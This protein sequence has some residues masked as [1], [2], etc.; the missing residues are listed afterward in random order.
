MKDGRRCTQ[1]LF[2]LGDA[3]GLELPLL[4]PHGAVQAVVPRPVSVGLFPRSPSSRAHVEDLHR[5]GP[6]P[7]SSALEREHAAFR[8]VGA[9]LRPAPPPERGSPSLRGGAER[10]LVEADG[11]DR[12]DVCPQRRLALVLPGQQPVGKRGAGGGRGPEVSVVG[13]GVSVQ[14]DVQQR[15]EEPGLPPPRQAEL[16]QLPQEAALFLHLLGAVELEAASE[17]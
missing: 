16:L 8:P 12:V 6:A 3:D 7:A 4:F 2:G 1:G 11:A 10:R 9:R 13:G 14:R 5:R 17:V 15:R